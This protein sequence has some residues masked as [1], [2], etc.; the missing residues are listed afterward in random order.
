MRL[1]IVATT[2]LLTTGS[3]FAQESKFEFGIEGGPSMQINP[4]TLKTNK[5]YNT[6]LYKP[7]VGYSITPTFQ[8]NF[9]RNFGLRVG[10]GYQNLRYSNTN[11]PIYQQSDEPL[12][13]PYHHI[14]NLNVKSS[15]NSFIIPV[16]IRASFGKKTQF[17]AN[18]GTNMTISTSAKDKYNFI[19]FPG[20]SSNELPQGTK[21]RSDYDISFGLLTGVGVKIPVND[22]LNF[23]ME[24]RNE[25]T[26]L[27]FSNMPYRDGRYKN[28]IEVIPSVLFGISYKFK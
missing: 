9:H 23:T 5:Y 12:I 25:T 3:L 18:I 4:N 11:I 26:L 6:H 7:S 2:L 20:Q 10:L 22:R 16:Q 8:Y 13:N 27:R 28:S 15:V 19:P 21:I 17:F 14:G 1:A 24:A